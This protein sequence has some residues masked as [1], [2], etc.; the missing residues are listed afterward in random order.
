MKKIGKKIGSILLMLCLTVSCFSISA[1]AAD[2][3]IQ[4][5]DPSAAAGDQVTVKVKAE[6]GTSPIGDVDMTVTYDTSMLKFV[7]GTNAAGGDGTLQL[8][9]KGDGSASE[10]SYTLEFTALKE[11]TATLQVTS[12]TAYLYND[13]T[14]NLAAGTSTVT[15]QGGTPV[16]DTESSTKSDS[17]ASSEGLQVQVDGKTYTVNENFSEA[18]IP[19]GFKAVDM[20]LD[21]KTAKAMQQESSG[22]YMFYLEDSDGNSD[23]FL[24]STDDGSFSPTAV[25]DVNSDV[26]I[27]LMNHKDNEGLP[28]EYKETTSNMEGKVFNVW[29]NMSQQEYYLVYALSSD[30]NKGY[31]QYDSTEGTY[32]RYVAQ[33]VEEEKSSNALLDKVM[34]FLEKHLIVIMCVLWGAFLLFLI[35]IIVMGVKLSHRNQELDELYDEYGIDDDDDH[36][37]PPAAGKKSKKQAVR[38]DER[39]DEADYDTDDFDDEDF[40]DEEDFEDDEYYDDEEDF[41][42][43]EY[44]DDEED[45]EDIE[46]FDDEEFL[47]EEPS[48]KSSKR[49]SQKTPQKT[50]RSQKKKQDDDYSVDFIDI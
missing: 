13:Q 43:D 4:F 22:Q 38:L 48:R 10:V 14:L 40:D 17:K 49:P 29:Q 18:A 44:Y 11:G 41:E 9:A 28:S 31:Y 24:Y 35:I 7:S 39:E 8:S 50:P 19:K 33:T 20:E 6:S 5:S 36:I 21:G 1:F 42:D 37:V 12:S 34:N 2:G 32:Q 25:V 15:I 47:D 3:T 16:T 23:Y 45:F 30:G 46:D 26:S 27:Y